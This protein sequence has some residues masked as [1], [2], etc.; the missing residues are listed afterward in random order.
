[1]RRHQRDVAKIRTNGAKQHVARF[2]LFTSAAGGFRDGDQLW[3]GDAKRGV[4][5]RVDVDVTEGR[6]AKRGRID[7]AAFFADVAKTNGFG[8][9]GDDGLAEELL[10]L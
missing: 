6:A 7:L 3:V 9:G 5:N 4:I 1:M 8:L 10:G 2:H